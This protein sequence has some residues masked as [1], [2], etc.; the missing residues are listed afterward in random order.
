MTSGQPFVGAIR[1][2]AEFEAVL[3]E[4]LETASPADVDSRGTWEYRE[5][6][7]HPHCESMV[8][9]LEKHNRHD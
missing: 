7:K 2:A 5:Y 3:G 8:V 1:T 4:L 6:K 9:E